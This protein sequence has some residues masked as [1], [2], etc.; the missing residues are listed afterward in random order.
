MFDSIFQVPTQDSPAER[1]VTVALASR[2][3]SSRLSDLG[4]PGSEGNEDVKDALEAISLSLSCVTSYSTALL[5]SGADELEDDAAAAVDD[6]KEATRTKL[7]M[8]TLEDKLDTLLREESFVKEESKRQRMNA[9][10]PRKKE[11]ESRQYE[12]ESIADKQSQFGESDPETRRPTYPKI[13]VQ[14]IEVETLVYYDLPWQYV[15]DRQCIVIN[16]ELGKGETEILFEHTKRLR[17]RRA[18]HRLP[19]PGPPEAMLWEQTTREK[20][21]PHTSGRHSTTS[22]KPREAYEHESEREYE[23][24]PERV[25]AK[26]P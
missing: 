16:K 10:A 11:A 3:L 12:D 20:E 4:L 2:T 18:T 8:E 24:E 22:R 5:L 1:P 14:F 21:R 7:G 15:D 6:A 25:Y 19:A 26:R 23:R 17:E 13:S 9:E